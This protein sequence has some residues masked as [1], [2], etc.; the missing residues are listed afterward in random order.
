MPDI[1]SKRRLVDL[2][3]PNYLF[4]SSWNLYTYKWHHQLLKQTKATKNLGIRIPVF[5]SPL[6]PQPLSTTT[7][8]STKYSP[9]LLSFVP[10]HYHHSG[11]RLSSYRPWLWQEPP[12]PTPPHSQSSLSLPLEQPTKAESDHVMLLHTANQEIII[13]LKKFQT[14]CLCP[15]ALYCLALVSVSD[16]ILHHSSF[17]F[18]VFL[19]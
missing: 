15:N 14:I 3:L 8:L 2:W 12:S 9:T 16:L 4:W 7:S 1:I 19:K 18:T 5:L 11:G 13:A 10:C 6:Q 17:S